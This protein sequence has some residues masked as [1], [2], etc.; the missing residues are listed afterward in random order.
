M[1]IRSNRLQKGQFMKHIMS[2]IL[3]A[4]S[5]FPACI[6][7]QVT[8]GGT[9]QPTPEAIVQAQLD[10]Y[11]RR[12]LDGFLGFYADNAVLLNYPD[13]VTQTGKDQMRTRYARNFSNPNVRAEIIKRIAFDRFVVDHERLTAPP[14]TAVLEATAIYEVR[15]GKIIRVT[16][17]QK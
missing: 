2:V 13:Q 5:L 1:Y 17:L 11:N 12:D 4:T 9:P 10:A 7:A 15:D 16:F 14:S 3:V 8:S 6:S